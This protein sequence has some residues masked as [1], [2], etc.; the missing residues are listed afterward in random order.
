MRHASHHINATFHVFL[1]RYTH[2]N[3]GAATAHSAAE[4]VILL[5]KFVEGGVDAKPT[6][7]NVAL[8]QSDATA[9][10][11]SAMKVINARFAVLFHLAE[12]ELVADVDQP[13]SPPPPPPENTAALSKMSSSVGQT[14]EQ[15][16]TRKVVK[17]TPAHIRTDSASLSRPPL[18]SPDVR[19]SQTPKSGPF[20][21]FSPRTRR[22]PVELMS[23]A[24]MVQIDDLRTQ[25]M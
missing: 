11:N 2:T 16:T 9:R 10:S 6:S 25:V 15:S 22:Q 14:S 13:S 21:P 1:C 3:N 5:D 19:I 4:I 8:N 23:P 7:I 12:T 24:K 17:K 20:S 18:A